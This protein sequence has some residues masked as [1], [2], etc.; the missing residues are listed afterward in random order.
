[1]RHGQSHGSQSINVRSAD[2]QSLIILI[3]SSDTAQN[4][5]EERNTAW[6]ICIL[7]SMLEMMKSNKLNK[8]SDGLFRALRFTIQ[9]N[10]WNRWTFFSVYSSCFGG[11]ISHFSI[12]MYEWRGLRLLALV[13]GYKV[14]AIMEV[15]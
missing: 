15:I 10:I 6:S 14:T 3:W 8:I 11:A 9:R 5:P 4:A 7:M 2:R 13:S 12:T 1:M